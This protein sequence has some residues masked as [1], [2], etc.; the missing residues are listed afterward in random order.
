MPCSNWLMICA[1][2]ILTNYNLGG[3]TCPKSGR[4]GKKKKPN[5]VAVQGRC[6]GGHW[7]QRIT[8]RNGKRKG[9]KQSCHIALVIWGWSVVDWEQKQHGTSARRNGRVI[10]RTWRRLARFWC[11]CCPLFGCRGPGTAF[12]KTSARCHL[13][14]RWALITHTALYY[15]FCTNVHLP[16]HPALS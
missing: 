3:G 5:P 9:S 16:T 4:G 12:I 15:T 1:P 6:T 13:P 8:E 7:E 10:Q 2:N 14:L 11:R